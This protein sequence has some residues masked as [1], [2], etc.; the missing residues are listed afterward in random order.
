M[1]TEI[2]TT[3]LNVTYTTFLGENPK[4]LLKLLHRK[5]LLK[6]YKEYKD[7]L[8]REFIETLKTYNG[9]YISDFELSVLK[10]RLKTKLER[11]DNTDLEIDLIRTLYAILSNEHMHN[12]S[13]DIKSTTKNLFTT[14]KKDYVLPRELKQLDTLL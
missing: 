6:S 5:L 2:I 9:N 4:Y 8:N 14:Y 13:F 1:S 7:E 3:R 12:P 11:K 10:N